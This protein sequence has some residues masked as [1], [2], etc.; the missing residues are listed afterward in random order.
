MAQLLAVV[1]MVPQDPKKGGEFL[2]QLINYQL[3]KEDPAARSY[4]LRCLITVM[5]APQNIIQPL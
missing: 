1:N 5:C 4:T 2:D 3:L